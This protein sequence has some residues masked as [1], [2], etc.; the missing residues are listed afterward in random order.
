M[1]N[2]QINKKLKELCPPLKLGCIEA[3]VKVENSNISLLNEINDYCK[4][5]IN[6]IKLEDLSSV[7]QIKCGRELYKAL[8]KSPGKCRMSSEALLRRILQCKGIYKIN[9]IVEI[10]NLISIKSKLPVGS[11]NINNLKEPITLSIGEENEKYKGIGK[12]L[13]NIENLPVFCDTLGPFGSPTS[14]SERAMI[15]RD[16]KHI[17]MIIFSF[18]SSEIN[19]YLN[20]AAHLLETYAHGSNIESK[21]II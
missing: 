17:L 20:F 4:T 21:I 14:D 8:G 2:I 18:D 6:E 12:D 11:Y 7:M 3:H 15:T 9:N 10:N 16:A 13:I 5:I 19:G 1:I